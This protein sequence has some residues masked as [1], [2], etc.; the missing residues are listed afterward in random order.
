MLKRLLLLALVLVVLVFA[1]DQGVWVKQRQHLWQLLDSRC[2]FAAEII[3]ENNKF[4]IESRE[5]FSDYIFKLTNCTQTGFTFYIPSTKKTFEK[6]RRLTFI[7]TESKQAGTIST[8]KDG[9]KK[10]LYT[11]DFGFDENQHRAYIYLNMHP[12]NVS[13]EKRVPF[14]LDALHDE[15]NRAL[16]GQTDAT[17]RD[18]TTTTLETVGLSY[19]E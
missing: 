15:I 13:P 17:P 19:E 2:K 10:V 14:I 8:K 3:G 7:L 16:L 5:K 4:R 18:R 6:V 1:I 9:I 11:Y 12:E